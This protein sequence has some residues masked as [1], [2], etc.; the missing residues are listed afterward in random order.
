M[1]TLDIHSFSMGC[2]AYI[3]LTNKSVQLSLISIEVFPQVLNEELMMV[4]SMLVE[5]I[6]IE[7]HVF[8][9]QAVDNFPTTFTPPLFY[10]LWNNF[11]M[12]MPSV[13]TV[14]LDHLSPVYSII[15]VLLY[16]T[17][18]DRSYQG[19]VHAVQTV[20]YLLCSVFCRQGEWREGRLYED[21]ECSTTPA[22]DHHA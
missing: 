18:L 20:A 12:T 11:Q 14:I 4:Y 10:P 13:F 2:K 19:F 17:Q 9:W 6:L 21:V 15:I 8:L 22:Q 5:Y 1:W 7:L 16:N 3:S